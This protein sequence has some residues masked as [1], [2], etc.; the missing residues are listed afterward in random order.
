[1]AEVCSKPAGNSAQGVCD[2]SGNLWEWV[3]NCD[4]GYDDTCS[5][6]NV[7]RGGGFWSN[8]E[9]IK[10]TRRDVVKSKKAAMDVGF[11]CVK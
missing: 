7:Q 6:R 2:L 9:Q 3:A 10:A 11:R 5:G 4:T 8:A 1:M